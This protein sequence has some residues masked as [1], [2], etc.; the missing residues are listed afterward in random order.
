MK[1]TSLGFIQLEADGNT[2]RM[3]GKAV[4]EL[5]IGKV[6]EYVNSKELKALQEELE[7][8]EEKFLQMKPLYFKG[9]QDNE[10]YKQFAAVQA[11]RER[12]KRDIDDL[13][14]NIFNLSL[15]MMHNYTNGMTPRMK[16]AYRLLEQGDR[17]GCVQLLTE[18]ENIDEYERQQRRSRVKREQLK[19]NEIKML[20]NHIYEKRFAIGILEETEQLPKRYEEID[21]IYK[22][23]IPEAEEYLIELTLLY[24]YAEFFLK[25]NRPQE[26]ITYAEKLKKY[27]DDGAIEA[28]D[29]DMAKLYN[30][31]GL[32]YANTQRSSEAEE[33]FKKALALYEDLESKNPG[34]YIKQIEECKANLTGKR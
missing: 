3:N 33:C 5:D 18:P 1:F 31:L 21:S 15:E 24:D 4:D 19:E 26:G 6:S 28:T 11:K 20:R 14:Q 30:L 27:Y 7:K 25:Q 10:F 13:Q 22:D 34:Q 32:L 9:D 23:I 16:Q 17:E 8:V 12:L 2:L 29:D